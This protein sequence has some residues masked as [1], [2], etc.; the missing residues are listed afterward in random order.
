M[1]HIT[2]CWS[3]VDLI[4]SGDPEKALSLSDIPRS[5]KVIAQ[6]IT[7]IFVAMLVETD[8]PCCQSRKVIAHTIMHST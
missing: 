8:L 4:Y 7:A 6:P 3:T 1:H 5:H 2:M